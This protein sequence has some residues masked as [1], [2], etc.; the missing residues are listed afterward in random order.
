MNLNHEKYGLNGPEPDYGLIG[1]LL[2][3]EFCLGCLFDACWNLES[4]K[5]AGEV[6]GRD[7]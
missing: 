4:Q 3:K 1:Q 2:T 7:E 6:L 5:C